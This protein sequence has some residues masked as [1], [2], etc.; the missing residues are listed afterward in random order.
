MTRRDQPLGYSLNLN[1]IKS[2][3]MDI[4]N[5]CLAKADPNVILAA[6]TVILATLIYGE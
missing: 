3:I 4:V 5:K 2:V 1:P 6:A